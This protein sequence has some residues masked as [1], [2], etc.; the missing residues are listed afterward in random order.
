MSE[1]SPT[2]SAPETPPINGTVVRL[3]CGY[4]RDGHLH[5]DAEIIPMTGLTRKAIARED[6]RNNPIKVTDIILS[7]CL[8]RIGPH[9]SITSKLLG[10]LVIGDR[11]FLILEIRRVSMG[12]VIT[13]N[14]E[15]DS[16]KAKVEVRFNLNEIE[17]VKMGDE[18]DYPIQNG[19]LTMAVKGTRFEAVCRFPK[20]VDQELIMPGAAKN[21]VAA[22]YGLYV[23]CLLEWNGQKGPFE[24][25]FFE[26][27]PLSDIDEFE[28]DFMAHQPGPIMKQEA[29]CPQCGAS[30]DFTFRGSDFLFRAP[31]R[32]RI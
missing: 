29:S 8:K 20:G 27:L 28:E 26:S 17:M 2:T 30:I 18:K 13:A 16:C 24:A 10:D 1:E 31:K 5:R 4:L 25:S 15:C 9:T 7:H 32:G 12:D 11:D 3:P 6:T 14:V 23:A 22:S 19:N 21:P